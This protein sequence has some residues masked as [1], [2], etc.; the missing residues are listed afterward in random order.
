MRALVTSSLFLLFAA[1]IPSAQDRP[2]IHA[3]DVVF[4]YSAHDPAQYDAYMGTVVGW[5][6]LTKTRD[7]ESVKRFQHRVNEAT[8]RGMRYCGSINFLVDFAGYIDFKPDTFMEAVCRDLN[9]EPLRVPWLWDHTHKGHPSYWFCFNNPDVQSYLLDQTERACLAPIEGLHIDD[10]S[11]TSHCSDFNGG[12]FCEHCM[13]GFREYLRRKFTKDELKAKGVAKIERFHYGDFLQSKEITAE[14]YKRKQCPLI[15]EFQDYQN[16]QMKLRIAEVYEHAEKIRGKLL[17]RSVNSS[18][19]SPRTILPYEIIDYFCGEIHQHASD[20]AIS[21]EP[22][23]VYRMVEAL[24]S[25]QTA[26]ASGQDWAW[27]K[28]NEK[29][30]KVKNWIAQTYAFGSVFMVPHRQ[31]CYTQELGTHWWNGKPEDFAYLY[32]FVRKNKNLLDGYTSLSNTL[33]LVT[34]DDFYRMKKAV[35]ELAKA[36]AP[37]SLAYQPDLTN[38]SLDI[39][40]IAYYDFVVLDKSKQN[41]RNLPTDTKIKSVNWQDASTLPNEIRNA[42]QVEGSGDVRV[43]LRYK[44]GDSTAP[45]VCH[46][47]NQNYEGASDSNTLV[48][49]TIQIQESLL[50]KAGRRSRFN[51]AVIHQ[52]GKVSRAVEG[53][54]KTDGVEVSVSDL[55]LWAIV[56]LRTN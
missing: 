5:G 9:G 17:V 2:M 38:N 52:P 11:G 49:A 23:F 51:K 44:A 18:A 26:T 54:Q 47:L 7:D 46:V 56:E 10:Y 6:G 45:I 39:D 4:M 34:D 25:R 27:I 50:K 29:P 48:D 21:N 14:E 30:G 8:T 20:K 13:T 1:L 42:I 55:D 12:C 53:I 19:S 37:I 32:Q 15:R 40:T 16:Q 36:N 28:A 41:Q 22:V 3:S 35:V 24:N 43:S 31:W 33:V